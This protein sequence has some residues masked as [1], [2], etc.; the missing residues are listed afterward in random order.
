M[1]MSTQHNFSVATRTRSRAN[2]SGVPAFRRGSGTAST[3]LTILA[4]KIEDEF[5]KIEFPITGFTR[6]ARCRGPVVARVA[7]AC[8]RRDGARCPQKKAAPSVPTSLR[9]SVAYS[10][11]LKGARARAAALA[12]AAARGRK[13]PTM[14]PTRRTALARTNARLRMASG[15]ST[16]PNPNPNQPSDGAEW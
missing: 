6:H 7:R 14:T 3:L 11:G 4:I 9:V 12:P 15:E 5:K 10:G 16:N 1:T 2:G 8:P 13:T